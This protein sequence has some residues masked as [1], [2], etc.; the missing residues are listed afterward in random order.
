MSFHHFIDS[1]CSMIESLVPKHV[2][3]A[4]LDESDDSMV[5]HFAEF[6]GHFFNTVVEMIIMKYPW[7]PPS[8]CADGELGAL[9]L[10]VYLYVPWIHKTTQLAKLIFKFLY[11]NDT[12]LIPRKKHTR[13]K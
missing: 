9:L 4:T 7:I 1:I 8:K 11:R 5:D 10:L 6:K 2:V 12:A 3:Q 13:T